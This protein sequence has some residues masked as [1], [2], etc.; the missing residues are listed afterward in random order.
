MS[1]VV[2]VHDLSKRYGSVAALDHVEM[3]LEADAVHGLLGRNGAGKT[4]LLHILTGQA[5]PTSGRVRVGGHDPYENE[6]VLSR[7]CLVSESQRYPDNMRVRHALDAGALLFPH[8]DAGFA[9]ALATDF[10]LP[11][12]RRIKKLSRGMRSAV[13]IVLGL[14]SRAPLTCFDE[15]YLGLDAVAR[16]VFYD[17]LLAEVADRPRTVVLSTHLIDEVADLIEHVVIID[18]G[19][20]VLDEDS[21][22]LRGR[23]VSVTGPARAVER[24]A[25]GR[26]LLH[27]EDVGGFAR[28][29][30]DGG[31]D[32]DDRAEADTAGLNIEAV[33]LQQL[34]VRATAGREGGR[35]TADAGGP[36]SGEEG[37]R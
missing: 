36:R 24:F 3:R 14:A 23:A 21:D 9:R 6:D 8:W 25:G 20:L 16:Q 12:D 31:L 28:V 10:G 17:R 1:P 22:R 5:I 26:P 7:V 33:S 29:T 27:R 34:V 30:L 32:D 37:H 4:T 13:G 2:E 15:P 11:P 18:D 19:R 35:E